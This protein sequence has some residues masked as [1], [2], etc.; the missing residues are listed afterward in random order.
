MIPPPILP[1]A[2]LPGFLTIAFCNPVALGV[3]Y[4]AVSLS[5]A[6]PEPFAVEG[7]N[8][9]AGKAY[10]TPSIIFPTSPS[11]YPSAAMPDPKPTPYPS[12]PVRAV[13]TAGLAICLPVK[14]ITG[15]AA[16]LS[17]LKAGII[18]PAKKPG[19]LPPCLAL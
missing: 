18:P 8:A 6:I 11:L 3:K 15:C 2:V 5:A 14:A 4:S 13:L 17:I 19:I 9:A 7:I 12:S 10:E 1:T 16:V